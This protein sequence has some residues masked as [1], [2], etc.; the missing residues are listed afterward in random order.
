MSR[1]VPDMTQEEHRR[2]GDATRALWRELARRATG[3]E[4]P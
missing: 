2:R 1:D 3:K 4:R